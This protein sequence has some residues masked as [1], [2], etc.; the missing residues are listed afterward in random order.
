MSAARTVRHDAARPVLPGGTPVHRSVRRVRRREMA[1]AA[2]LMGPWIAGVGLFVVYPLA[3]TV[4]FSFTHYNMLDR[5][6]FVGLHNWAFVLGHYP[7]FWTSLRNTLWLVAVMVTLRVIA[8]FGL[9]M[10]VVRVR[11][12]GRL[13]RTALFVPY[14]VPPVAAALG[15][16]YLLRPGDGP[17]NRLLGAV[18]IG[19]PGWFDDPAWSKAALTLLALWGV[20]DVMVVFLA[21]LADVP[22]ARVEAALMDGATGWQR[23]RH[24]TLPEM[25]PTL[26]FAAI[27]GVI[28]ALQ[29]YTQAMVASQ[30]ASGDLA[31]PGLTAEPGFPEQS[32]L[33]LTQTLYSLGF[34][35]ADTGAASVVA[36]ILFGLSIGLT[37]LLLR[38][39]SGFAAGV[40]R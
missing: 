22:K 27:T 26:L 21:A 19:G 12:G 8:G 31:A 40:L 36:V 17:V 5:P 28:A 11:I 10:L 15:F 18:G 34:I 4:Y 20:G 3:A 2:A 29:Y 33:T 16:V 35:H 1:T 37:A 14:L 30:A 32:T 9:A 25:S 6:R 7:P 39:R 24:I 38:R 13:M 23:F